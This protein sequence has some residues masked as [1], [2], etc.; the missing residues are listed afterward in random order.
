MT[1]Q[2]DADHPRNFE[3]DIALSFAGEDR[4]IAR[5]L[6]DL[7]IEKNVIVFYDSHARAELWGKDHRHLQSI[8]RDKARYCIILVS[9]AYLET[10]WTRYELRQAQAR[11]FRESREYILPLALDDTE[12]PGLNP[13]DFHIDLRT[14]D[15]KAVC[16]LVIEKLHSGG[17]DVEFESKQEWADEPTQRKKGSFGKSLLAV[18]KGASRT[19]VHRLVLVW[20]QLILTSFVFAAVAGTTVGSA[21]IMSMLLVFPLSIAISRLVDRDIL[22]SL[23]VGG[24]VNGTLLGALAFAVRDWGAKGGILYGIF[25]GASLTGYFSRTNKHTTLFMAIITTS[26]L[27]GAVWIMHCTYDLICLEIM[28]DDID[29]SLGLAALAIFLGLLLSPVIKPITYFM[30]ALVDGIVGLFP[31]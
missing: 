27:I 15:L 9:K 11:A 21:L 16:E 7:L 23:L 20:V 26:F 2:E 28:R 13:T 14:N 19:R 5:E 29:K 1:N 10:P 6:A 18:V 22:L 8:Y 30:E 25:F 24:M 4:K 3:F 12:L 31:D 17:L